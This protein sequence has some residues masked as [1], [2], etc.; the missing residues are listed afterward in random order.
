MV[1]TGAFQNV[2]SRP[3]LVWR[4][5]LGFLNRNSRN[6]SLRGHA[7]KPWCKPFEP[8]SSPEIEFAG[9]ET[10]VA[11]LV[12]RDRLVVPT[13]VFQNVSSRPALVWRSPLFVLNQNTRNPPLRGHACKPSRS[14]QCLKTAISR[15]KIELLVFDARFLPAAPPALQSWF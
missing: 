7:C 5:P 4:L 15:P 11:V 13:G 3:A 10:A 8:I 2:T 1:P 14:K 9:L 6:P 12:G